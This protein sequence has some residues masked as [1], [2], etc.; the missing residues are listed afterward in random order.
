MLWLISVAIGLIGGGILLANKKTPETRVTRRPLIPHFPPSGLMTAQ[1]SQIL[2]TAMTTDIHPDKMQELAD[3]FAAQGL[4]E[5]SA[6]IQTRAADQQQSAYQQQAQQEQQYQQQQSNNPPAQAFTDASQQ[7]SGVPTGVSPVAASIPLASG[8]APIPPKI[9]GFPTTPL[10]APVGVS[11][12]NTNV[13]YPY[14][15]TPLGAPVGLSPVTS[16]DAP[17][18]Q[19]TP[20]AAPAGGFSFPSTPIAATPSAASGSGGFTFIP[21]PP[22]PPPVAHSTPMIQLQTAPQAARPQF[23][24]MSTAP[25]ATPQ[26]NFANLHPLNMPAVA[27]PQPRPIASP[28]VT[29]NMRRQVVLPLGR[30]R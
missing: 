27:A 10:G 16:V 13:G 19:V 21:P 8:I 7:A 17:A 30:R 22:P 9:V 4:H 2:N 25:Q 5:Q 29:M 26:M 11:P 24:P 12:I 15:T 20:A 18:S 1:R 14:Q 23:S 28:P 3:A 6:M